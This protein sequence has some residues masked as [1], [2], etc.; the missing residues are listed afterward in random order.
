MVPRGV[1]PKKEAAIWS[2]E[3]GG[4]A[5]LNLPVSEPVILPGSV[6]QDT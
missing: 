5:F 6:V 3:E 2:M 4:Q 1:M